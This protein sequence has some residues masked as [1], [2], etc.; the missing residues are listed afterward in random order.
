MH[1]GA[2]AHTIETVSLPAEASS[3]TEPITL[4]LS[5]IFESI[6]GE[7]PTAGAPALFV[8]LATC[9]LHCRFCDTKYTWDWAEYSYEEQVRV[10]SVRTVAERVAAAENR[11]LVITGGEPLL[12]QPALA[13]LLTRIARDVPVEVETNGTLEPSATLLFRVDQWNVSPKLSNGGDPERLR[14]RSGPLRTFRDTARAYLKLVIETELDLAEADA[15]IRAYDWPK[16][17]VSF[18][19]QAE[20]REALRERTPFVVRACDE[21]GI[22]FSP[23]LHVEMWGG[24]RGR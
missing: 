11:R 7:G 16:E 4:K 19:P 10:V 17:R 23:R 1:V 8:R 15:L 13:R 12:Q 6:Q 5:E 14:L 22:R 24:E 20:T 3:S 2:V 9:N 18:M 21:R